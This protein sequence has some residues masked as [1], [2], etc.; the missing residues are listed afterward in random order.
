MVSAGETIHRAQHDGRH[1][2][3]SIG[4]MCGKCIFR[5]EFMTA[6]DR[7]SEKNCIFAS[8]EIYN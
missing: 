7:Y 3:H 8:L 4:D 5:Q 6:T 1:G 2:R